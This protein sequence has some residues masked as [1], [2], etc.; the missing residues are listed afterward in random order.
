[1]IKLF[2]ETVVKLFRFHLKH[3]FCYFPPP[4]TFV[5]INMIIPITR[6]TKNTPTPTPVL[7]ISPISWQ[8]LS[9][10]KILITR[11]NDNFFITGVFK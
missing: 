10:I 3:P 1:M 5:I 7:K 8:L 9:E 2:A 11:R 6:M 4:E